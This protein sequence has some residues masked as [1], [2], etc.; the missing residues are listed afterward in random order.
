MVLLEWV[1]EYL[2]ALREGRLRP[3]TYIERLARAATRGHQAWGPTGEQLRELAAA[4]YDAESCEAMFAVLQAAL[5]MRRTPAWRRPYKALLVLERLATSGSSEAVAQAKS[6]APLL[7]RLLDFQ[8]LDAAGLDEG[9]A[10]RH[11]AQSVLALL[12]DEEEL[13]RLR[14]KAQHEY[15]EVDDVS[16]AKLQFEEGDAEEPPVRQ[17]QPPAPPP[18]PSQSAAEKERNASTLRRLLTFEPNRACADC[19]ERPAAW[20]SV[21]IGVLLCQRCAGLHR[22]L[23]T[24]VSQV[25]SVTLDAWM[26]AQVD[27][28]SRTGN[29]RANAHWE[30]RLAPDQKLA[31]RADAAL[32]QAF[33]RRKYA[34]GA[35]AP[36]GALWPPPSSAPK[37][38]PPAPPALPPRKSAGAKK[39]P[40]LLD[41]MAE[42]DKQS[43]AQQP[44]AGV[45][46]A[47][48]LPETLFSPPAE[49]VPVAALS[50]GP[51]HDPLGDLLSDFATVLGR[52]QTA[53]GGAAAEAPAG[54]Q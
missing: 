31:A 26:T 13:S 28:L 1:I 16:D 46:R 40:L 53:D 25:R 9:E 10:V 19:C 45:S 39:A 29:A 32:L 54:A 2:R 20:A 11:R 49:Q 34:D 33:V 50:E 12:S 48:P 42:E 41:L 47:S 52:E 17:P 51:A 23:G 24:H 7:T 38:L 8:C 30:A 35:F 4:S 15:W 37:P 18:R 21:N 5:C 27:L 22:G 6:L 36:P 14:E 44:G 3:F 43:P